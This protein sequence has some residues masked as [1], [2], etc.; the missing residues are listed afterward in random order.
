[1]KPKLKPTSKLQISN[2]DKVVSETKQY[3]L[4]KV[5]GCYFLLRKK[6]NKK[7]ELLKDEVENYVLWGNKEFLRECS[8]T[9]F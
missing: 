9:K 7:I 3:K 6:D 4:H 1:M 2:D 8:N 5:N